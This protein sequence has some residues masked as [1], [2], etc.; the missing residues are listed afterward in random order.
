MRERQPARAGENHRCDNRHN[1]ADDRDGLRNGQRAA[2][3]EVWRNPYERESAR[4]EPGRDK[5]LVPD[6]FGRIAMRRFVNQ[7]GEPEFNR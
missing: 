4:R 2:P 3:Q 7:P 6:P 5:A 1:E